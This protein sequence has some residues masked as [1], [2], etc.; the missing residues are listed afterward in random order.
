MTTRLA[1]RMVSLG[2]SEKSRLELGGDIGFLFRGDNRNKLDRH[3]GGIFFQ[4]LT[5]LLIFGEQGFF[6]LRTPDHFL[7]SNELSFPPSH[8]PRG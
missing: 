6:L 4:D 3:G 8:G 2:H 1:R 5:Y 7:H